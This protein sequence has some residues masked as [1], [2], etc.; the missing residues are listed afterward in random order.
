MNDYLRLDTKRYKTK[1]ENWKPVYGKPHTE[2]RTLTGEL[3]ITYGP[4]TIFA[5]EGEIIAP[6]TP[7]DSA[8]GSIVNLRATLAKKQAVYLTDHLG[9]SYFVHCLGTHE[10]R[11]LMNVWDSEFNV[12]Y[13][14]VRL[15]RS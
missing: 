2:R 4:G 10:E 6:V 5:W 13:V 1:A 7:Q 12:F 14:S 3:D 11:S 15:V 8:W 9:V